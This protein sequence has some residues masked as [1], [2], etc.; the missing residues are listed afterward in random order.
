[1]AR[2]ANQGDLDRFRLQ[3]RVLAAEARAR[4]KPYA[5][6]EAGT[7]RLHLER[8]AGMAAAGQA[9]TING[10]AG[11]DDALAR[12][13][14]PADRAA[15]LRHF[16]LSAP[17]PIILDAAERAAVVPS[18]A[19][20][21]FNQQLLVLAKEAKV[22]YALVWQTYYDG[23]ATDDRNDDRYVYY[24]VPFPGHPDAASFQ[25]FYADPATC[26]LHDSACGK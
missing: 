17:G 2:A 18:P 22:A 26:F 3:L 24:Y 21:W 10:K 13:F 14:D 16:G 15:L 6:T 12:L 1:M 7:Y 5:L 23:A 8:L 9:L 20:D 25:R 4:G 11:V 19:E